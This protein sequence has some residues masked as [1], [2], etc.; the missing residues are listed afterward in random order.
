MK[1]RHAADKIRICSNCRYFDFQMI[2]IALPACHFSVGNL[3]LYWKRKR[4][5]PVTRSGCI[6]FLE[7]DQNFAWIVCRNPWFCT[8]DGDTPVTGSGFARILHIVIFKLIRIALPVCHFSV[9]KLGLHCTRKRN[10]P[11]TRSGCIRFL[12]QDRNV[13][14]VAKS[15]ISYMEKR[16]A[17]DRIR[18][19][20]NSKYCDFQIDPD[21][22]T[23]VPLFSWEIRIAL[24]TK[25]GHAI[26][27]TRSEW[28]DC[29]DTFDFVHEKVIRRWQDPDLFEF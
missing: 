9:G 6:R 26:G 15:V 22:V 28:F 17:G 20:S 24:H 13:I 12:E 11:V 25:K 18:I 7:Q 5:T 1:K 16:Y 19:C 27:R 14:I 2:R 23:G 3:G 10:T 4:N 29:D 21:R 8:W